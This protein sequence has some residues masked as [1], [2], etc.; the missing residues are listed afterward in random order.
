M[1]AV[2]L[3][4]LCLIL[5]SYS[6]VLSDS[7]DSSKRMFR[8]QNSLQ[9]G[10]SF[11]INRGQWDDRVLFRSTADGM[12]VWF[13]GDGVWYQF[14]RLVAPTSPGEFETLP[15]L[16]DDVECL[17]IRTSLVD[18]NAN[19]VA[20]GQTS[21]A[22]VRNYF[23]GDDPS[24]WRTGIESYES[25]E[26]EEVYPGIDLSYY[27]NQGKLEY[28][29]IVSPGADPSL[30][31]IRYDGIE[32]LAVSADGELLVSTQWG[33]VTEL[34]PV[35]YQVVDD[36]V[37]EVTAEYALLSD[38]T[39]SFSLGSDYDP[40]KPLVIDP[41]LSY[42]SYV[43]GSDEERVGSIAVDA[44]G[45]TYL[46]GFTVSSDFPT[47]DSVQGV[48]A[49][50]QDVFVSKLS[51]DGSSLIYS[52]YLGGAGYDRGY[53][54]DVDEQG[55]AYV[56]G[57]TNS[58]DFPT[59]AAYQPS[60]GDTLYTYD[61]FVAKL[62][63]LGDSLIYSTYL[64]GH[65]HDFGF[66]L[67]VDDSGCAYVTGATGATDFPT[68]NPYQTDRG[69]ADGFVT[70][71]SA[72][73]SS[74]QYST[75]LGGNDSEQSVAIDVDSFGCAYVTGWTVS[76][77]FPVANAFQGAHADEGLDR[78]CFVSKLST[79]GGSLAYSTY[80][81]GTSDDYFWGIAVDDHGDAFMAGRS[82]STDFPMKNALQASSNGDWDILVTRLGAGGDSLVYSTYVGGAG[83]DWGCAVEVDDN[84]SAYVAGCTNSSDFPTQLPVQE[85]LAGDY[86]A[87]VLALHGPGTSLIYS[88]YYGGSLE[89][90]AFGIAVDDEGEAYFA[91]YTASDDL[92]VLNPYQNNQSLG[93]GFVAKL[94]HVCLDTDGDGFGDPGNPGNECTDD[95]CPDDYNPDQI[96]TD[97]DGTGDLC[98]DDD[99][100]DGFADGSDN[101]PLD[102]NPGQE[103]LDLDGAGD[104]CD[105]DDD[106]DD[107][108]DVEDN[109]PLTANPGQEDLDLD[110]IGDLCDFDDD[111]DGFADSVD[112]CP[113]VYNPGQEDLDLDGEGDVCDNDDDDDGVADSTDNCPLIANA[114]QEDADDDGAGNACD[115][116]DDDDGYADG[117]D[118]CPLVANADQTDT[119][120]DGDGDACDTDDDDD[121]VADSLDNCPLM[122]NPGQEDGDGDDVG[123][124]CDNCVSVANQDQAD[125]DLDGVGDACDND[126]D[127]D[128]IDDDIDNCPSVANPVQEDTDGDLVG[129]SCDNCWEIANETQDDQDFDMV[130]DTCDNC[131]ATYNPN[132]SD[133][134]DNGLGD[135]CDA[136]CGRFTGGVTGN[137]N[138]S[139]DGLITLS[140]IAKL[141]DNV[142]ISRAPLVCHEN[143]NTNGSTDG[144]ITLSDITRVI[145]RVYISKQDCAPCP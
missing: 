73:G 30:I 10:L 62:S 128:G 88:T 86:D 57:L 74:L 14:T 124:I 68:S 4:L 109:C 69:Y 132:Q 145:D 123:N 41:V 9:S 35:S 27:G 28:D 98:D 80:L 52:T 118:N 18:G 13:T 45:Y 70:K 119:D 67:A 64:G 97:G 82:I 20:T 22:A 117:D 42:S 46:V 17:A 78:D 115:D 21:H 129:D 60:N 130:G 23:L 114:G 71:F 137:A 90:R 11:T 106:D 54:V 134:N 36:E 32:S 15:G 144:N 102:F 139:D 143:G 58:K 99:D 84:G 116:D 5:H 92:T 25:I 7:S 120:E 55:N 61:V 121:G 48:N 16:S 104:I 95:N 83:D 101:C 85:S 31:K 140:D 8:Q 38:N 63:S 131:P 113:M 3:L 105:D 111:E 103:D 107:V 47:I 37:T 138:F 75:Y 110:G 135:A 12:T 136:C 50:I 142:Y 122:A 141:I 43:G 26:I 112:N 91:G 65:E 89:D 125:V 133:Y 87:I 96:D 53:A 94:S 72:D 39:F 1:K 66:G 49:G 59:V 24:R 19:P 33:T 93:D 2:P 81:G 56:T 44:G 79:D 77:D 76:E 40:E 6:P 29:F 51:L 126:D 34:R 127:D 100:E 108:P